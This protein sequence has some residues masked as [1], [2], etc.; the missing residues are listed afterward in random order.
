MRAESVSNGYLN[1]ERK[2]SDK[3]CTKLLAFG[4]NVPTIIPDP[5]N[6]VRGYKGCGSPN[7]FLNLDVPVPYRSVADLAVNTLRQVFRATHPG[8]LRYTA[9]AKQGGRIEFPSLRIASIK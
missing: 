6:D 2:L 1:G 7:Y 9:F 5:I 4:W 3:A 8:Q